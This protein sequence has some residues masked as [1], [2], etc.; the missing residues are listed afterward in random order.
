M[1]AFLIKR[2]AAT[3]LPDDELWATPLAWARK[4]ALSDIEA[5][6]LKHG[7]TG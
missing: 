5:I 6:L 3:N 7:A 4:L 1:V 2:G